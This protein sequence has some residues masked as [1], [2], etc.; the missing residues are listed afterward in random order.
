MDY[1]DLIVVSSLEFKQLDVARHAG[2]AAVDLT[3]RDLIVCND[4]NLAC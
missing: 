4:S 3:R 2:L 1:F